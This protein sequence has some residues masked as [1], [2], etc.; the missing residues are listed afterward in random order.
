[1]SLSH[2]CLKPETLLSDTE[3]TLGATVYLDDFSEGPHTICFREYYQ[4]GKVTDYYPPHWRP[5]FSYLSQSVHQTIA[6]Q[7]KVLANV[8]HTVY[9]PTCVSVLSL[10]MPLSREFQKLLLI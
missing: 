1:M 2:I 8:S 5:L 10:F 6:F 7:M 9:L 3:K 4:K